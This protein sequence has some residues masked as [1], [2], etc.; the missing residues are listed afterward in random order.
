[1]NKRIIREV[2]SRGGALEFGLLSIS[3]MDRYYKFGAVGTYQVHCDDSRWVYS[4]I[5]EGEYALDKAVAMF[6]KIGKEINAFD[7]PEQNSQLSTVP[8]AQHDA[9]GVRAGS[10]V[11]KPQR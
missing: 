8:A 4:G 2:V 3:P 6:T 1:M 9:R 7:Y 5:F 11:R 10:G